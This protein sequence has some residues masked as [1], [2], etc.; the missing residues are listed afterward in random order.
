[1]EPIQ[2]K[3]Q[4]NGVELAYF[5]RGSRSDD[6]PTLFFVHATG[7][8]ARLWDYQVQ[9][10][11]GY[12]SIALDQRGHGRSEKVTVETWRDFGRDQAALL[13]ELGLGDVIGIAHSMG[14]HAMIDGAAISGAF[15]RLLLLD[16]TVVAPEAYAKAAEHVAAFGDA[17]HPAAK[18][19]G[20]FASVDEML[21][22]IADKSSF[23]LMHPRILR[24]YCQFGL[25]DDGA[26]GYKLACPPELEARVYM[27]SRSN[28][29]IYDSVRELD[30]PVTIVRAKTPLPGATMDFSSSPTWPGLAQA[31]P[32]GREIFWPECSHFIPMQKPDEVIA[33]IE[34]E[35]A[36]WKEQHSAAAR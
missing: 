36:A 5:E 31:F 25:L 6:A 34:A 32:R 18:R 16:P 24:D 1:M 30:I 13:G 19:R 27:T 21:E 35:I 2:K 29:A 14:G 3:L 28:G 33:L 22:R 8:H 26:G 20:S 7:F 15:S 4:V 11:P 17:L 9:A 12:H 10:F 23:P